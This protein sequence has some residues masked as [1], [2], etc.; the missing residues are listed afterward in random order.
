MNGAPVG[1]RAKE[2]WARTMIYYHASVP[3]QHTREARVGIAHVVWVNVRYEHI[4]LDD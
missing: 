3:P 4:H 2:I 1:L